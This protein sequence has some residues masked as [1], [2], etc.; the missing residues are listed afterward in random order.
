MTGILCTIGMFG[1]NFLHSLIKTLLNIFF[2]IFYFFFLPSGLAPPS[3]TNVPSAV[4]QMRGIVCN[5]LI[6]MFGFSF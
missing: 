2:F 3:N 6:G 1:Y 5:L 4:V